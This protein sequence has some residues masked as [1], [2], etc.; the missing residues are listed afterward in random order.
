M[1][2]VTSRTNRR[3]SKHLAIGAAALI[4]LALTTTGS[5]SPVVAVDTPS[6][7][8]VVPVEPFRILDTRSGVGAPQGPVGPDSEI[9]VQIAGVA[10]VP[11]DATGVVLNITAT[12][13]SSPSFVSAYP[14]GTTRPDTSVLNITPGQDLPNMI[15]ATLGAGGRIDLYNSVGSVHLIADVAAYLVPGSGTAEPQGPKGDTGPRGP[16]G[17]KGDTGP[18]GPAGTANVLY[19]TWAPLPA[20]STAAEVDGTWVLPYPISAPSVT[21]NVVNR[22]SVDVYLRL[23]GKTWKL[24]YVAAV[25]DPILDDPYSI[26]D[27]YMAPGEIVVYRAVDGCSEP[28]CLVPIDAD[29]EIRYVVIPG[30]QPVAG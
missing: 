11:L 19:S 17:P 2:A 24:P 22:G 20:A 7:S 28:S 18:Q 10:T 3:S 5:R 12:G 26:V 1:N 23:D 21:N 14:T 16:A 27:F 4:A 8:V 25:E 6:T 13:G 15:T 29:A 9:T 30:G